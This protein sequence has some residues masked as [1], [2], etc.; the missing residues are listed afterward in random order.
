MIILDVETFRYDLL[1]GIK[2]YGKSEYKFYWNSEAKEALQKISDDKTPVITYNGEHYDLPLLWNYFFNKRN[3]QDFFALSKLIVEKG[4]ELL[5][6]KDFF[7][8][9]DLLASL[10]TRQSLKLIEAILGWEIRETTISFDYEFKLTEEERREVEHYNIQDLDASEALYDKLSTYFNLR[11]HLSNYLGIEHDYT[12]PLPTLMGMGL[13]AHRAMH[14]PVEVSPLV[15]NI[16]IRYDVKEKMIAHME[17]KQPDF[18]Y[19]FDIGGY[20]YT[21][22]D[23]GIHSNIK[24][25]NADNVYHV[26]VKGY[27]TLL[28]IIFDLFSRNIPLEGKRK[29]VKMYFERLKLKGSDLS[30]M[31]KVLRKILEDKYP[32]VIEFLEYVLE[33]DDLTADSLKLGILATWGATRN[34]HHI[35]YDFGVGHLITLYGQIFIVYLIQLCTDNNVKV[36]NANTDGLIVTGALEDIKHVVT[37]WQDYG[38]FDVEV[39][40]YKRFIAKDVNNYIMGN[41]VEKLKVKGRDFTALRNWLFTNI[42]LVP[43]T[44]IISK[45]QAELLFNLDIDDPEEYVRKRLHDFE[46]KDF[47][48]IANHTMR[49][50]GMTFLE[51]GEKM[52]RTNRVYASRSGGTVYKYRGSLGKYKLIPIEPFYIVKANNRKTRVTG[53]VMEHELERFN[54]IE[55]PER[56]KEFVWELSKTADGVEVD[57]RISELQYK[58]P[59]LPLVKMCNEDMGKVN[60]DDLDIDYDFYVNEIMR[61]YT[62]YFFENAQYD[63]EEI[64]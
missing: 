4:F 2:T 47:M 39:E 7:N 54:S 36:L 60:K 23:G 45:I 24:C 3:T 37:V 57:H 38:G 13:G 40:K 59:G 33:R 28:Q 53:Y 22:G 49:F 30:N 42:V 26:D 1:V 16:P 6:P 52:Q 51:T 27:Y 15:K 34:Y 43:Q 17:K 14:E 25:V 10:Q 29:L 5:L 9:I 41:S 61:R 21:V 18:S 31:T 63:Y 48:F 55:D 46:A 11:K 12:I 64:E 35:L 8:S 58:Y 44:P 20:S 62:A 32:E 19:T 56:K 50:S